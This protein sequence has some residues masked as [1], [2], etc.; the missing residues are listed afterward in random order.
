MGEELVGAMS[1]EYQHSYFNYRAD[2]SKYKGPYI[3]LYLFHAS[4][5]RQF[6]MQ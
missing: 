3:S 2:R 1:F 5:D 4:L 6:L